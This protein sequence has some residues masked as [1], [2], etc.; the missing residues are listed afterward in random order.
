MKL[1]GRLLEIRVT[2]RF[3]HEKETSK[4]PTGIV[5]YTRTDGH[6]SECFCFAPTPSSKSTMVLK[7]RISLLPHRPLPRS[8]FLIPM[9]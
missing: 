2:S 4:L 8:S 3:A 9:Q 5:P 7:L 1:I 6:N